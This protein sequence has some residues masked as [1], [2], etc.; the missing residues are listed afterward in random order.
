MDS[1]VIILG[2]GAVIENGA[3]F[4]ARIRYWGFREGERALLCCMAEK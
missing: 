2:C 1:R 3:W 4:G